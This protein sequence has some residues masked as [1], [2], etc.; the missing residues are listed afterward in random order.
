MGFEFISTI[1]KL[2]WDVN[3]EKVKVCADFFHCSCEYPC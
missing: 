2:K 3:H 1:L